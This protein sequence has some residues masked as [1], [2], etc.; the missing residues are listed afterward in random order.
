MPRGSEAEIATRFERDAI[1]LLDRM[2]GAALRLTHNRHD[3]EDLLQET[4]L[5][6]YA[7]FHSFHEGTNLNAWL[8]RI[9]RNSWID[10]YRKQARRPVVVSAEITDQ[11]LATKAIRIPC[12]AHSAEL[13]ALESLPDV[14]LRAAMMTL[15]EESRMT[16]YYADVAGLKYRQIAHIMNT[17]IGTVMS[18][19]HRGRR[20]LRNALPGVAAHRHM[21]SRVPHDTTL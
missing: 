16:V 21:F 5:L 8:Y 18:R 2:Y 6:A 12:V 13:V 7:G 17:S 3:A 19:L 10:Q 4:T 15:G 20:R 1:P 11:L 9:M 14:D